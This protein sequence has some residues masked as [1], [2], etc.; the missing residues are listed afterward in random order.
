MTS[1]QM[2]QYTYKVRCWNPFT[3]GLVNIFV[4]RE[5]VPISFL[6]S[7]FND[8]LMG[9]YIMTLVKKH[10]DTLLHAYPWKCAACGEPA[11]GLFNRAIPL[12]H[13][14]DGD[15]EARVGV[16]GFAVPICVSG[17][18]CHRRT[19]EEIGRLIANCWPDIKAVDCC[20]VCGKITGV[21]KC[22]GCMFAR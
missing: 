11:R 19:V 16:S 20:Q 17:G 14:L 3:L 15:S 5:K 7:Q 1:V 12:L 18:G 8:D 13:N 4:F 9:M 21:G 10:H 22:G 2:R 6:F